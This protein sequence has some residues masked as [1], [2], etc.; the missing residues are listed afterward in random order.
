MSSS[1]EV[2]N[3]QSAY[4]RWELPHVHDDATSR[5]PATASQ[6][7]A[8]QQQAYEEGFA[9]GKQEGF[10]KGLADG[11]EE[12]R[13]RVEQLE[14][15]MSAL[16]EPFAELDE[17]VIEQT[18]QLAMDVA[19]HVIRRE[20]KTEPGQVIAVVREAVNALPVSARNIRVQLHPEDAQLVREAL[21]LNETDSDNRLWQVVEE[22]L[23]SRGGCKVVAENSTIDATIEKQIA[24]ISTAVF[25]GERVSDGDDSDN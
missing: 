17:Q 12:I 22:P 21:S 14:R 24:R 20:L 9:Q 10:D 6:L 1:K 3:Q 19:R 4:E 11:Q 8:V 23:I 2:D 18:G 15:L 25:G 13:R 16:T 5:S 7:E